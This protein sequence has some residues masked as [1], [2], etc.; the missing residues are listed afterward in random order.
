MLVN[1]NRV[2]LNSGIEWSLLNKCYSSGKIRSHTLNHMQP[3]FQVD[4]SPKDEDRLKHKFKKINE[5][6]L[7]I[8][9]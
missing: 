8:Y 3:T 4:L 6:C 1:L 2:I 5:Y 9:I 7:S